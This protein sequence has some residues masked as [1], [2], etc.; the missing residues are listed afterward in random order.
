MATATTT[1]TSSSS[2][3]F[4]TTTSAAPPPQHD[5]F[6]AFMGALM[7][8]LPD[9]AFHSK[10]TRMAHAATPEGRRRNTM[11]ALGLQ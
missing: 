11:K 6:L 3:S 8:F 1:T 4:S 7:R 5:E 10:C 9:A 2:S